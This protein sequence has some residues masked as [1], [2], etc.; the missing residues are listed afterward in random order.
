MIDLTAPMEK[1][2]V[3]PDITH[4]DLYYVGETAPL[5]ALVTECVLINLTQGAET[6]ELD[7]LPALKLVQKGMSVILKTGWE[8]YRGTEKYADSPWVDK[9]LIE[10]LVNK[11]VCLVL[12]DSPGVFGG[13]GGAEH[14]QIDQY[15]ADHHAYAVENLVNVGLIK[16]TEFT[17]YC[18]P[19]AMSGQNNAPCRVVAKMG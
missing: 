19:I 3:S 6:V 18:F 14:N 17:L 1:Y 10:W 12:I 15:L 13:T 9:R 7:S 11:G 5:S 4:M 16:E 8:Q 2:G